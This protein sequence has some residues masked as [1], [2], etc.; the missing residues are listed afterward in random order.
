M[1]KTTTGITLALTL[2]AASASF[3]AAQSADYYS[4]MHWREIGPTRAGRARAIAGVP[5]QPNVFYA[6]FDNG[7]LW[8]TTDYGSTWQPLF[9]TEPVE[10]HRRG[11]RLP[12]EP[13]HHLRG[14]RRGH[15]PARPVH[16]RRHVQV[17]RRRQDVDAPGAARDADDRRRGRRSR[18]TRTA[19]SSRPWA[20]PYGPNPERG[21][22]RSTDGGK[23]FKKVLYRDEYTS[24]NNVLIDPSNP[25]VVYATSLAAAAVVPG[26]RRVRRRGRRHLQVHR[27]RRHLE[28]AHRRGCPASSRPT[29][30]SRPA[31]RT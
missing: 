14:Q 3:A 29:W 8:R 10:L 16:R 12:G 20:I 30:P 21:I 19:S 18:R 11:G 22:F 25:K 6:G 28:A 15:H 31:T 24:G 26:E 9:D 2:L 7:G 13:E 17:H 23:T 5:S 27:R 4:D 1:R